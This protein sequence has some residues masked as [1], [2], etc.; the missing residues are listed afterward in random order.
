MGL[1]KTDI[2]QAGVVADSLAALLES[3]AKLKS[4]VLSLSARL[5]ALEPKVVA[6]K[7][8]TKKTPVKKSV[9]KKPVAKAKAPAKK[10]TASAG[11]KKKK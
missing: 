7:P 4:D 9:S 11:K 8:V 3:V 10:K 5:K 1:S 2:G 6:K